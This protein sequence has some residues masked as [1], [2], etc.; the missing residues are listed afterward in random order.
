M[1]KIPCFHHP[2]SAGVEASQESMFKHLTLVLLL[3]ILV[4]SWAEARQYFRYKD[5]NGQVVINSSI[6]PEFVKKGYEIV[7]DKGIVLREVAP[8]LSEEEIRRR[9]RAEQEAQANDARDAEL[10]KLYRSPTDVDRAMRT[11]LSR[12]DVEIR[13]KRNRIA[14]QRSEYNDLQSRAANQE[15]AGQSVDEAL[16]AQ[17]QAIEDEIDRYQAEIEAVEERQ[18]EARKKFGADRERMKEL[19]E[20]VNDRPWV[21][22]DTAENTQ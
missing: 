8:Q 13:L 22:P 11:W 18:A 3:L 20:R 12:L 7:D 4:P 15:R 19:Y 17:M 10:L 16:L 21:E 9:R 14:I 2:R 5:E 1:T 6:P